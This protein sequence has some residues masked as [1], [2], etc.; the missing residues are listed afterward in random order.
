MDK[1]VAL[2]LNIMTVCLTAKDNYWASALSFHSLVPP[3]KHP[4]GN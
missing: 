1:V 3:I 4:S 2:T